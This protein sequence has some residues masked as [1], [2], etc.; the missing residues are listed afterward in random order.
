[1]TLMTRLYLLVLLAILPAIGLLAFQHWHDRTEHR[2]TAEADALRYAHLLSGELDRVVESIRTL[3]SAVAE[4]PVV[5]AFRDPACGEYLRRLEAKNPATTSVSV[6]DLNGD[7]RCSNV[8]LVN[9][10][11][12][13]Y[14]QQALDSDSLVT[15]EYV[16]GKTSGQPV[17]P[18]A[19]RI[20]RE[21]QVVGII[22]TTLRLDWLRHYLAERSKNFPQSSSITVVDRGATILVRIPNRERE[23]TKLFRYPQLL[24]AP[25]GGATLHSQAGNTADGV[26]RL[27]G[28]T[29]LVDPPVGLVI[30][31]GLPEEY[32]FAGIDEAAARN[33]LLLAL[34]AVLAFVAANIVGRAFIIRPVSGLLSVADRLGRGEFGARANVSAPQSELGRLGAAINSMAAKLETAIT[35]K[36]VLLQELSHRVMNSLHTLA[37][38]SAMQARQIGDAEARRQVEQAGARIRSVAM[39]YRR[40]HAHRGV[41]MIEFSVLLQELCRELQASMLAD[42]RHM[43]VEA[44]SLFLE[45]EQAMPLA[46][47]VN[48]LITNAIKHGG[49]NPDIHVKLVCSNEGARLAVRNRGILPA[50]YDA[51]SSSGFGMRMIRST[52]AQ[53]GGRLEAMSM[54]GMT[55]FAVSFTPSLT[56]P[57]VFRPVKTSVDE[58]L[59]TSQSASDHMV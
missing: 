52:V 19:L 20:E 10:M 43:A 17:L 30:A 5:Q 48:E 54:S 13:A 50:G 27:L 41:E 29:A 6:Y 53:I 32:V 23:G 57:A 37:S 47:V 4:A 21:G 36:D 40:L 7:R 25:A 8:D 55:E 35:Y 22:V 51:S 39:A 44:A 33:F 56:Q 42:N 9:V 38:I 14:F 11:D 34:T 1:M 26:A 16:V 18:F 49:D 45:P 15:G 24:T 12:R 31:V 59:S 28:Y 2:R 46:L 58:T 3:L